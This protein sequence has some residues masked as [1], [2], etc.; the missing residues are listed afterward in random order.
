MQRFHP[1]AEPWGKFVDV[2]VNPAEALGCQ[3]R[4]AEP[5]CVFVSSACDGWQP[6]EAERKLTRRCCGLLLDHG[7]QVSVLTKSALVF[8]T[9]T[10]CPG[11]M[12]HRRYRNDPG[13]EAE[14]VVGTGVLERGGGLWE[15]VARYWERKRENEYAETKQLAESLGAWPDLLV[16]DG[17]RRR[18]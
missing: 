11:A 12:P 16:P 8:A 2:T 4:R 13:R 17:L 6:L 15:G 7:F 1:H 10:C 14:S 5:G 18:G 9:W 3:L